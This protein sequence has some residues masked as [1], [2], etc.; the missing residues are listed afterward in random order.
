MA[1][2]NQ[3]AS[4]LI[5]VTCTTYEKSSEESR[6]TFRGVLSVLFFSLNTNQSVRAMLEQTHRNMRGEK[7][8]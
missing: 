1:N 2:T 7:M 8:W 6:N 4:Q 3:K 5:I